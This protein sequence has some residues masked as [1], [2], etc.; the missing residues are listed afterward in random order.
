MHRVAIIGERATTVTNAPR[1]S[2]QESG[3]IEDWRREVA[4]PEFR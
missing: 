4:L 2:N 3:E 1:L